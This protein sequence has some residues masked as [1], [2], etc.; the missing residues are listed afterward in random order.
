[1]SLDSSLDIPYRLNPRIVSAI[2]S[3]DSMTIL[4][5][6]EPLELPLAL[7]QVLMV[8]SEGKTARQ[9]FRMLETDIDLDEFGKIIGDFVRRELLRPEPAA[10]D[11]CNQIGRASC[12]ER[13]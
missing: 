12:R 2:R 6:R 4:G 1:M 11:G 7:F 13:V 8:F 10:D 9:A 5:A 3:A